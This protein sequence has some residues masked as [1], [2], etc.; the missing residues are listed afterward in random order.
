MSPDLEMYLSLEKAMIALDERGDVRA[1]DLRDAM[2]AIWYGLSEADQQWL[3]DRGRD[4]P[5]FQPRF[6]SLH[7]GSSLLVEPLRPAVEKLPSLPIRGWL[8]AAS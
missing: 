5:S 3:N 4:V 8:D 2:D 1:D 7:I 6:I